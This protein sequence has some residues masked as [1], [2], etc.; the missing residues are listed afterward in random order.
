MARPKGIP[1]WNKGKSWE[2]VLG[3]EKSDI[4][5]KSMGKKNIG[6][7]SYNKGLKMPERSGINHYYFGKKFTEEHRKKL[8]EAH[9]G[10]IPTNAWK[11]GNPS[12]NKGLT[13]YNNPILKKV[14]EAQLGNKNHAWKGDNKVVY[15][16]TCKN[17]N[18]QFGS[19]SKNSECCSLSCS[20][21]LKRMN[22]VFPK[23][24]TLIEVKIQNFLTQ[25]HIEYFAHKYISEITHAY[26]CD[27]FIP[28]T[29]T[30][31]ETDGCYWHGC[32]ICNKNLSK[33]Q[34][35]QI[36]KDNLRNK[37]LQE[38]G[39]RIIRLWEHEINSMQLND[40]QKVLQ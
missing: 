24:D 22:R 1:A 27:I 23:E 34:T 18:K 8:S 36:D 7:P 31:I 35:L 6:R 3:K 25:L 14:S 26:Q 29:K 32:S 16:H 30:I 13:K 15:F 11:K 20:A 39:F 4:V 37:E 9:K 38:K 10:V 19:K 33:N 21:K 12:W 5:K 2:E 40:F 17:C 28:S